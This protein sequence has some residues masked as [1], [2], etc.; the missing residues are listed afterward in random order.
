MSHFLV[1][2]FLTCKALDSFIF[3]SSM[4]AKD[5]AESRNG[6]LQCPKNSVIGGE[7]GAAL[8]ERKQRAHLS[9]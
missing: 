6:K 4:E 3:I 7:T 8:M 2:Q 1:K 5:T 9:G